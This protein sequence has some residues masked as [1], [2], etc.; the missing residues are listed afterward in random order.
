MRRSALY[1]L[2]LLS[3]VAHVSH[4]AADPAQ[5]RSRP[6]AHAPLPGYDGVY[7][8]FDGSVDLGVA[9]GAEVEGDEA[10]AALRASGHAWWT[11]GAYLRYSD[12]FGSN[13]QRA[14]RVLGLGVDLR[15]LFL[16]RFALDLERGPA[17]LDLTL[18][19]VSLSAGAYLA[20]PLRG[21]FADERGFDVGL[22]IGLPLLA[23]ASGPW[24]EAR[25]ER[26][27]ADRG[28]SAWLFTLTA[29]YHTLMMSTEAP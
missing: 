26:R 3:L 11:A 7:G 29:S 22:G 16:P 9:A 1:G 25:A 23:Q 10:R 2:A 15:P 21:S 17:W 27:F 6:A 19:S 13:E 24:L 12:G 14:Q 8:R 18:D 4:A 20:Q 28:D 5:A